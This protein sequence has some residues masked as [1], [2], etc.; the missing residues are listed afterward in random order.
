M[1]THF[2]RKSSASFFQTNHSTVGIQRHNARTNVHRRQ[3]N[4][5]AVF[6]HGNFGGATANVDVHDTC[7]FAHGARCGPRTKSSKCGFQS[8]TRADRY[9]LTC[10][11]C[12]QI[13]NGARITSA[14]SHA[15]ENQSTR[16]NFV[17]RNAS[18]F[19][20]RVNEFAQSLRINALI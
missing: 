13:C 14:H 7:G 6:A 1:Q 3:V 15:R 16:V 19:I 11:R 5:L 10:L 4:Q 12:K 2:L 20:L 17:G 18:L 8:I 9:K